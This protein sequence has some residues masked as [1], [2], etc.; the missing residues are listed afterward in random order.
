MLPAG[1]VNSYTAWLGQVSQKSPFIFSVYIHSLDFSLFATRPVNAVPNPVDRQ[2]RDV[3]VRREQFL[4]HKRFIDQTSEQC[5]VVKKYTLNICVLVFTYQEVSLQVP[6][7][8]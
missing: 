8:L 4:E 5:I 3:F 1:R 2:A 6:G 7:V